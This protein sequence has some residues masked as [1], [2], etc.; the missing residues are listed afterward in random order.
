MPLLSGV[1]RFR[2]NHLSFAP[3]DLLPKFSTSVNLVKS[4]SIKESGREEAFFRRADHRISQAGGG[5]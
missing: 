4:V 2:E 3:S 1:I 5:R